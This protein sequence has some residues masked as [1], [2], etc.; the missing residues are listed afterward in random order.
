MIK[1]SVGGLS[2]LTSLASL[3]AFEL[4]VVSSDLERPW[5]VSVLP[6]QSIL[7]TERDGQLRWWQNNSLSQAIDVPAE[8]Y[9]RGQG[10]LL[11][12]F[13]HPHF[14]QNKR[15]Y[16]TYATG[17]QRK[18]AT[19]LAQAKFDNGRLTDFRVLFT[20]TP[21]KSGGYHFAGRIAFLP[22]NTLVFGVGDGYKHMD[23]AQTLDNH[24]GKIIRLKDDGSV[25][26][27]N[28]FIGKSG[29]LAEIYS[30]GHRNPQGLFFDETT[31]QLLSN[32]HG[33]KGGDE[34]NLIQAGKNYGWPAITYGVDY[35]GAVISELTHKT[36]ML[37]PLLHWTPSIAP[38][39]IH[40]Y[41]HTAMS[42]FSGRLLNTALKYQEIRAVK[43]ESISNTHWQLGE[44]KSHL[45]NQIGRI[46]DLDVD[47]IGR[48]YLVTD[49]GQL[50]RLAKSKE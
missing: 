8:I 5:A 12:V 21:Y 18:N 30:Y 16:L 40:F 42:E 41:R 32:E 44:Q 37:Q 29:V 35:S 39:S 50:V 36:G 3:A 17:S 43:V 15:I 11:D 26:V 7:I 1:T 14:S 33:P 25:P 31:G 24:L 27:D 10:G 46:R 4:T 28:P 20:A 48:V 45:K 9:K 49:K 38:S 23:K 22:D 6:D 34:I 2:L 19:R 47:A 13:P